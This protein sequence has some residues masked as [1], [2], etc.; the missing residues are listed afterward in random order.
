ML[1]GDGEEAWLQ[2][3]Y[4][5]GPPRWDMARCCWVPETRLVWWRNATFLQTGQVFKEVYTGRY[6]VAWTRPGRGPTAPVGEGVWTPANITGFTLVMTAKNFVEDPDSY[7]VFQIDS[8]SLGGISLTAPA[9]GQFSA[10]A[11]GLSNTGFGDSTTRLAFD[12]RIVDASSNVFMGDNGAIFVP[13]GVTRTA[14]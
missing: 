8:A 13:P 9:F 12:I 1:D 5:G 6:A 2:E 11:A 10:T 14:T 7:A 4:R 3:L